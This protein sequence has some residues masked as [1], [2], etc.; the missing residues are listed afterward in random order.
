MS[1]DFGFHHDPETVKLCALYLEHF[2]LPPDVTLRQDRELLYDVLRRINLKDMV[3]R[4]VEDEHY[5][6]VDEIIQWMQSQHDLA[7]GDAYE[8]QD[9]DLPPMRF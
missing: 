7:S 3:T 1:P 4:A 9:T 5:T 2:H 8:E 6:E